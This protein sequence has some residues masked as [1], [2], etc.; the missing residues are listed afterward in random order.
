M[1]P[2]VGLMMV[3][4]DE[5]LATTVHFIYKQKQTLSSQYYRMKSFLKC[6]KVH[7]T[8]ETFVYV[9]HSPCRTRQCIWE[10]NHFDAF[11]HAD[12]CCSQVV[13]VQIVSHSY[14]PQETTK[15]AKYCISI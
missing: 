11:A 10:Q 13:D 2:R 9:V 12:G 14:K 4:L 15:N 8:R 1:I 5:G 3:P 6:T 7:P